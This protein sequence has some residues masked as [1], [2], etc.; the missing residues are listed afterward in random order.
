M[1]IQVASQTGIQPQEAAPMQVL[2]IDDSKLIR[3]WLRESLPKI[4]GIEVIGD[5]ANVQVAPEAV[6]DLRPQVLII[7][8]GSNVK[9]GLD[10]TRRIK[11]GAAAPLIIILTNKASEQY[12]GLCA[13][14][15]ADYFFDK[16]AES[17]ELIRTFKRLG[18]AEIE[19]AC[20]CPSNL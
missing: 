6:R 5:S 9:A 14:V 3:D 20:L 7:D 19:T 16:A 8:I 12:R 11:E 2:I 17:L 15:G 10:V 4:D 1:Y 18:R 13:E